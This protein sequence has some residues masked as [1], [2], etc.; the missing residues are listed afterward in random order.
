M[1][2]FISA[3]PFLLTLLEAQGLFYWTG[4]CTVH[5]SCGKFICQHAFSS[6]IIIYHSTPGLGATALRIIR[7]VFGTLVM[8]SVCVIS[9]DI[10]QI[11][12]TTVML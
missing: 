6:F 2:L 1:G 3:P 10:G 12:I 7:V 9:K 4:T 5:T 11:L 8:V